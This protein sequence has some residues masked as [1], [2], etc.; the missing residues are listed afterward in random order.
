MILVVS[1]A[2]L[3]QYDA[4][5]GACGVKRRFEKIAGCPVVSLHYSE[6]SPDSVARIGPKAI[7]I[8]GFGY[9]FA[10]IPVP[11]LYGLNDLLHT[12]EIPVYGA[13]GGHQLIAFC[14]NKNLRKVK[15]LRDEP[16]RRLR[17]DETVY[18]PISYAPHHYVARGFQVVEIVRRD[19]IF[20]GL[21]TKFRVE[22]AHYCEV[23]QLP[24]DFELLA[25]SPECR[26]EMMRHKTRPI[27][28]AQ[29]HAENW[30][31]PYLDGQKI[32]TNFFRIAG[33]VD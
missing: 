27:Y 24:P 10:E 17:P 23:K 4:S 28:G 6:V 9:T 20:R 29:F 18:G 25:T 14:F 30:G 15:Q 12:T 31:P 19:P 22:E 5:D 7:F 8:T 3:A 21:G 33:L 11:D 32:F 26:I 13:C 16:I 1:M 2:T